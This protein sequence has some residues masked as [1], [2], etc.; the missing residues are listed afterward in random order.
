MG[1]D[2]LLGVDLLYL[3]FHSLCTFFFRDLRLSSRPTVLNMLVKN[4]FL[5]GALAAM[6]SATVIFDSD[7]DNGLFGLRSVHLLS[8]R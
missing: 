4:I 5:A 2:L 3:H 1:R 6:A 8:L 7:V